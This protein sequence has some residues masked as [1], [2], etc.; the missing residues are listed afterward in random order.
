MSCM[1][2]FDISSMLKKDIYIYIYTYSPQVNGELVVDQ[3]MEVRVILN[4]HPKQVEPETSC[5]RQRH[6]WLRGPGAI[7]DCRSW[8]RR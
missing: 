8:R 1:N 6:W 5:D 7:R 2:G 4:L 3:P